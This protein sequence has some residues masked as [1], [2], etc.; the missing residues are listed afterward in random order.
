MTA[1]TDDLGNVHQQL[2]ELYKQILTPREEV[3]VVGGEVLVDKVT[4]EPRTRMVYPSAAELAAA[5][6]FLKNNNITASPATNNALDEMRALLA[7]RQAKAPAAKTL[8]LADPFEHF[9]DGRLQ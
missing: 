4:G 5:N 1:S 9:P 2:A 7:K 3:I 6:T 8:G